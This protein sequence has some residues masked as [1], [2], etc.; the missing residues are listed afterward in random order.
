MML[1]HCFLEKK[2]GDGG[3]VWMRNDG[4]IGKG[5]IREI[6]NEKGELPLEIDSDEVD[7]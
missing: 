6:W 1:V 3:N 4:N 7:L 5:K 2:K